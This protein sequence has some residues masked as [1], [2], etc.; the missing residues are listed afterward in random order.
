MHILGLVAGRAAAE[1]G[2]SRV[3]AQLREREEQVRFLSEST[4]LLWRATP[5]VG[6]TTCRHGP[7]SIAATIDALLGH[8]YVSHMHP[9]DVAHKLRLWNWPGTRVSRS[10]LCNCAALMAPI[11]GS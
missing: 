6:S 2:R 4:A 10:K 8:G 1:L 9:D 5:T 7:P 3:E 11:A